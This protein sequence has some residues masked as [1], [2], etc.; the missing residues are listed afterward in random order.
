MRKLQLLGQKGLRDAFSIMEA[1]IRNE[2]SQNTQY[3][4]LQGH[5]N[6]KR[7]PGASREIDEIIPRITVP[8]R[9]IGVVR[10]RVG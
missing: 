2:M 3:D 6:H 8:T 9:H 7:C 10:G 4:P 1:H 5:N